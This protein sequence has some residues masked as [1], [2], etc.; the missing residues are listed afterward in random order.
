M[1]VK[2]DERKAR[3]GRCTPRG[4]QG[5]GGA[6]D[7]GGGVDDGEGEADEEGLGRSRG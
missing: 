7:R 3:C 1:T 4:G 5:G 2:V 6:D